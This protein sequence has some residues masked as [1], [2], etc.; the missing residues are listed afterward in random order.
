MAVAGPVWVQVLTQACE[1][2]LSLPPPQALGP[3]PPAGWAPS[4]SGGTFVPAV[5]PGWRGRKSEAPRGAGAGARGDTGI[6]VTLDLAPRPSC[7]FG[8]SVGD[9]SGQGHPWPLSV[10][11]RDARFL[12]RLSQPAVF[13]P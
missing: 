9:G 13:W 2:L 1:P 4:G 8:D 3:P 5:G 7:G 12:G 10:W 6:E 11:V